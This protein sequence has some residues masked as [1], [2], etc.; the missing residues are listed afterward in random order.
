MKQQVLERRDLRMASAEKYYPNITW[1]QFAVCN[2]D[3]TGAFEDMTR[4]LFSLEFLENGNIPH[5]E[6]NNPG[7]EVI[8]ILESPHLDGSKQ[9]KI[10]FQSKYFEGNVNYSK[11]KESARQAVKHYG[12]E[13]DLIYLFCNKPLTTTAKGYEETEAI[14]AEAGI[15][16]Y[17][18]SNSEVLDLVSKHKEI[19]HYFFLPRKRPD[20]ASLSQIH[21]EIIVNTGAD[22]IE[23]ETCPMQER[24]RIIDSILLKSF[25]Q[26][27]I[28]L[29]K[30]FIL[31]MELDKLKEELDK[32]FTYN[33][34]GVEGTEK[35][36]FY[37]LIVDLHDGNEVETNVEGLTNNLKNELLWLV[38]YYEKPVPIE[39]HT[40]ESHC[41]EVQIIA[42]DKMFVAQLWE[43]ITTLCEEGINDTN[44][45]IRDIVKQYY[46]LALFNLQKYDLAG[47]TLKELYQKTRKENVLFYSIIAE[48]KSTNC[49]WQE[50]HYELKDRLVE[51]VQQ[52]D[53]LKDNKQYKSN[54]NL[55]AMLYL[56]TA[57]N[58]GMNEKSYLENIV[59][60]YCDFSE[61]VKNDPLVKYLYALCIELNGNIDSAEKI[62]S[63]LDWEGDS[64]ISCRY[65][66]CKLSKGDYDGTIAL[67]RK[68]GSSVL[69]TKIKSLY[70]TAL[71]Y[72]KDDNYEKILKGF[73]DEAQ[74]DFAGM[75]DI[76]I[77]I[78]DKKYIKEHII[79]TLKKNLNGEMKNL[80][81]QQKNEIL[82]VLSA[83]EEME[84]ILEVIKNV[85]NLKKLNRYIVKEIYDSAFAI[86]NR[87]FINHDKSFTKSEKLDASEQIADR[88]LEADILRREFLQIK[89]L[90]AGAKEKRFSM[91]K[92]AKELFEITNEEGLAR[93]II[94]MLYERNETDYDAYAPYIN[95]L[96]SSTKP[97]YCIAVAFAMLR[98]GKT[99]EAD[100]YA[101][102]ALYY[103]NDVEDYGIY[104]SYF[105][106]YNQNLNRYHDESELNRVK[107]NCVVTFEENT[108]ADSNNP[109]IKILCLDSESEF[110]DTNN[111][112]LEVE[113]IPS[114]NPLF[115]KIQGSGLKQVLKID[116][117]NYR[118]KEIRSRTDFAVGFIFKKINQHP[119]KF[120]GAVLVLSSE[121]PEELL[122]KIKSM[123]NQTEQIEA[124][125]N[126]Y[127]FKEN[128]TGLPIDSFTNGDY[129]RYVDALTL[130]LH[131]KDQAFYTGFPT[132]ESEENQ[133]YVP[134]LSTM[135]LLSSMNLLNV[136]DAVKDSMILPV[137]YMDFF[138]ERYS[139]AKETSLVS[140]GKLV[141]VDNKIAIIEND[142]SHV[143]I[144]ERIVDFCA[145]CKTIEI[146]D[147]ERIGFTIGDDIN[148]EQFIAVA[149][150]HSIHLDAFVLAD[151]EQ[152]TLLCDDLFF[153]KMATYSKIRNINFVSLLH[154]YIDDDFVVPIIMELSKTNYLYIP[155]LARTD[156][157]AVELKKNILDGELKKKYYS[158]VLNAYNVAWK[159]AMKEIFGED[160]E[161]ED[162]EQGESDIKNT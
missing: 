145:D 121:K 96:R 109:A 48:I 108:P 31:G 47:D 129:D 116:G 2:D 64:D 13:L 128:E 133:K 30:S 142:L 9:R 77:G 7:V 159:K 11:I 56:E 127:H 39:T 66:I 37:K 5:S 92:Y 12:S 154:H 107:G 83:V 90:C 84:L 4:R 17:P 73:V 99:E 94:A 156:E 71:F 106:Y 80:G 50:G 22:V 89:Y 16:L 1:A 115:I 74:G 82:S 21:A 130:L 97:D 112:S 150:L 153:R 69:N 45:E 149:R 148:G 102:K 143:E 155:L 8:P 65:M 88:F 126:Y 78:H 28:E 49:A 152:A 105:G 29:C 157:E 160:I 34:T 33:I 41:M 101:Y 51:L 103:L 57:Y 118:I 158:D 136:L 123:T 146:S 162:L 76:A 120:D 147:E 18:I 15:E 72:A 151:K 10:S 27:K 62:Y 125:L 3:A 95:V 53:S 61:D 75:I 60:R 70:L 111:R 52:L 113:H 79:P 110:F 114:S 86:C 135:V 25:V 59:E 43:S 117:I 100:L 87:E 46:G 138:A 24:N 91:L 144:W 141:N 124:L 40:F 54:M 132:Y 6:H 23:C 85:S 42:L 32:I 68:L 119:E 20:E 134:S 35:L 137:S 67:Y 140:P 38:K 81:I 139:K 93:N 55:V 161:V 19:A 98:L 14:L 58:L 104:K 44:S 36:L 63:E 122:E 131:A 26:E